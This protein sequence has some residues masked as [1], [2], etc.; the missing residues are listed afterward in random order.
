MKIAILLMVSGLIGFCGTGMAGSTIINQN[1]PGV[2]ITFDSPINNTSST[3]TNVTIPT[4]PIPNYNRALP[5]NAST[6]YQQIIAQQTPPQPTAQSASPTMDFQTQSTDILIGTALTIP[7]S[8]FTITTGGSGP[9]RCS[10][11]I[12]LT[13]N[14]G[15]QCN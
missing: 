9:Q 1:C 4:S 12:T 10:G 15:C 3:T 7:A 14:N 2:G 13:T 8:T 6:R 5:A 11:S